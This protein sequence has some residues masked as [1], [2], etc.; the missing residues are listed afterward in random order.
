MWRKTLIH[1]FY[2]N[3]ELYIDRNELLWGHVKVEE[4]KASW[5]KPDFQY[6]RAPI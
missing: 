3:L 4:Y 5:K 1:S 2:T 6:G